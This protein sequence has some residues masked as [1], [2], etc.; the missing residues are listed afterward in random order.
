MKHPCHCKAVTIV[1]PTN[2]FYRIEEKPRTCGVR[3]VKLSIRQWH[4]SPQ[5]SEA[6]VISSVKWPKILT[7]DCGAMTEAALFVSAA[8]TCF[9]VV[10]LEIHTVPSGIFHSWDISY[11]L[12]KVNSAN[13]LIL[14]SLLLQ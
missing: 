3:F 2:K 4:F 7:L 5:P 9:T 11:V 6:P 8:P 14:R 12:F 13:R 10:L 1:I